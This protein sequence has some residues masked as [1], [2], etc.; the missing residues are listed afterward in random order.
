MKRILYI[1]DFPPS[2][3]YTGGLV[4]DRL[5]RLLP[6]E[7]VFCFSI[8]NPLFAQNASTD[9][10]ITIHFAEKP[11]E[12]GIRP[13][14]GWLGAAKCFADQTY[15]KFVSCSKIVDEAEAF[16]RENN[17]DAIFSIVEGQ[18]VVRVTLELARRT[19]LPLYTMVWDSLDWWLRS[20]KVDALTRKWAQWDF[21]R[22][23]RMSRACAT[24]SWAMSE[25]Y[26]KL[27]GIRCTP[28]ISSL[29]GGMARSPAQRPRT[30]EIWIGLA[31]QLYAI[32]EWTRLV[33]ALNDVNWIIDGKTVRLKLIGLKESPIEGTNL[34][35]LG[36]HPQEKVIELL[37]E[38]DICLCPYP[39]AAEMK[40]VAS[41]SFPSKL[42]SYLAAGRPTLLHGPAYASPARYVREHK[43]GLVAD[44]EDARH[45]IETIARLVGDANEY[46]T[47]SANAHQAFLRDF[48]LEQMRSNFLNVLEIEQTA[49][50]QSVPI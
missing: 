32:D 46:A 20:Y 45:L 28:V 19:K 47:M 9:L 1:T 11:T 14:P 34:E 43:V 48:T 41:T 35:F 38:M 4:I 7:S 15:T 39:F 37:S 8:I 10:P 40:D 49:E 31:G 25:Q 36:Y 23:M 18:T 29:P 5:C 50:K 17:V 21:D 3:D 16:A 12:E 26:E 2:K 44:R 30:D 6:P 33:T 24:A 27:Y 42:T 13:Y 22:L